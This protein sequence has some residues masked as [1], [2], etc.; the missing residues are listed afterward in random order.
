[1]AGGGSVRGLIHEA[2]MPTLPTGNKPSQHDRDWNKGLLLIA[3]I[4][5]L[6]VVVAALVALMWG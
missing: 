6:P 3:A 2:D 1:M 5:G 4:V